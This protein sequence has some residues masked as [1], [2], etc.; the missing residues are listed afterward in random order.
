MGKLLAH[1]SAH[2]FSIDVHTDQCVDFKFMKTTI[3][4]AWASLTLIGRAT[5]LAS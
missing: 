1:Q 2:E 3:P 5:R 4:V